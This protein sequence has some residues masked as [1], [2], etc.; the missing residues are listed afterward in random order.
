MFTNFIRNILVLL[1]AISCNTIHADLIKITIAMPTGSIEE[2]FLGS[3]TIESI[4][5]FIAVSASLSKDSFRLMYKGVPLAID[6][7]LEESGVVN[8]SEITFESLKVSS[9]GNAAEHLAALYHNRT[10]SQRASMLLEVA[11][12][13]GGSINGK[14]VD[15]LV[16]QEKQKAK[17]ED[18]RKALG[19]GLKD[20]TTAPTKP[21]EPTPDLAAIT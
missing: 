7:S 3:T 15:E 14:I 2:E 11:L 4:V 1:F 18:E 9:K 20:V 17:L 16:T 19:A 12:G 10:H 13:F 5:D 6:K 21:A 8:G